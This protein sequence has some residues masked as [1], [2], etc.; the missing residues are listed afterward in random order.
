MS[1]AAVGSRGKRELELLARGVP[2]GCTCSR[3]RGGRGRR[4]RRGKG[5]C[6]VAW[7][8][9]GS[10]SPSATTSPAP[11]QSTVLG[12]GG[13]RI[14]PGGPYRHYTRCGRDEGYRG[15]GGGGG[16]RLGF[17][18]AAPCSPS[19]ASSEL[20]RRGSASTSAMCRAGAARTITGSTRAS[21]KPPP[22]A[23]LEP[24]LPAALSSRASVAPPIAASSSQAG[25]KRRQRWGVGGVRARVGHFGSVGEARASGG[26]AKTDAAKREGSQV[27]AMWE[28]C[29]H[30]AARHDICWSPYSTY[31]FFVLKMQHMMHNLLEMVLE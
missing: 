20:W 3:Q 16:A 8:R 25:G 11:I 17:P 4:R 28:E 14:S 7:A 13:G 1:A 12:R 24:P 2:H 29:L 18:V 26:W 5:T 9:H 22:C 6:A 31:S 27:C 30:S 21:S 19:P 15:G 23:K 10:A